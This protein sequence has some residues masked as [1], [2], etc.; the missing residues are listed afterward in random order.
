MHPV[1]ITHET[2]NDLSR[3]E[4]LAQD[5]PKATTDLLLDASVL[6]DMGSHANCSMSRSSSSS[7]GC[8]PAAHIAAQWAM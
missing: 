2:A 3:L 8:R 4:S 1:V 6:G 5:L 7:W